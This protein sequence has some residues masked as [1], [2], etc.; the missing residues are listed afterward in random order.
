MIKNV[1]HKMVKYIFGGGMAAMIDLGFLG[2]FTDYFGIYYLI[3][4]ILA[5]VISFFFGFFFQKIITFESKSDKH[6]VEG[7]YFLIFQL[8]GL[9]INLFLLWLLSGILGF[10]YLYVAIFNK[11]VVFVWNFFMNYFFNFKD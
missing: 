10:N 11:F 4:A 1:A 3:S 8:I 5:F 7:T 2:L 9:G 6:I